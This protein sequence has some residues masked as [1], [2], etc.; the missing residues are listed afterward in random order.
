MVRLNSPSA[1]KAATA[2]LRESVRLGLGSRDA[3]GRINLERPRL[4]GTEA[5]MAEALENLDMLIVDADAAAA[6]RLRSN[7]DVAYVEKEFFIASPRPIGRRGSRRLESK[8]VTEKEI[9]W[10][11][12]AVKAEEAWNAVTHSGSQG[13]GV[14]VLVIDTGIDKDHADLKENFEKGKNF[15]TSIA[16]IGSGELGSLL[17]DS[18]NQPG[19]E[20][21]DTDSN[22]PYDFFDQVGHGSHVA[23]TIAGV[24]NDLGVAGVAPKAK[25]LAGRVCGKLGCS[26]VAIVNAI[27]WAVTEKVDV[28]NMSLGGAMASRAQE[29]ALRA[30]EAANVVSVAASG[31][32]GQ[33]RVSYPAAYSSV[34][35]V[36]ANDSKL[37]KAEFSN[38]GP[39]LGVIAPGVDILSAV[40]TGTGRESKVVVT[41]AGVQREVV[42]KSFVGSAEVEIPVTGDL[43]LAGLGK[44]ADFAAGQVRG[45]V[46]L[47]QRGEIPFADK[48]KNAIA[49]G[50][51]AVLI[52]NN[53]PGLVSGAI[54]QDG[55]TV[56]VPV[57]MIEQTIGEEIK[58]QLATQSVSAALS[59]SKTDF[60]AM[61]GTS[62]ASPHVAGVAAL[63]RGANKTLS[64]QRVKEIIKQ[65]ATARADAENKYGKGYANALA[66]VEAAQK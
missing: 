44:P 53:A 2:S 66:A 25:I 5:R 50:A 16:P 58:A 27:N 1:F 28:I 52:Y 22:M 10:G 41:L 32:D 59:T 12:R 54:T 6:E 60:A 64:A 47:I 56:A 40:P 14:R 42:S 17:F 39:E 9:T 49:A 37:E 57:A 26:S 46:A 62:M 63:V 61:Q 48:V 36:G 65:T 15:I 51:S 33:P 7:P 43:A 35:A 20:D 19:E 31:N 30:V 24:G 38:W 45:K 13:A 21:I 4:F 23:G 11:L 8:T 3:F 34:L 29:D 55:S 18:L